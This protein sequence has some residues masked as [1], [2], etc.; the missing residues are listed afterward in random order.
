L[1][2]DDMLGTVLARPRHT[3]AARITTWRQLVDI[4]A[5]DR[6]ET[7]SAA[8]DAGYALLHELRTEISREVRREA[9]GTLAG[10]RIPRRMIAYFA[11]EPAALAAPMLSAANMDPEDLIAL[12]P[13]MPSASRS[14]LRQRRDLDD[15]VLQALASFGS[16][17]FVIPAE[18]AVKVNDTEVLADPVEVQVGP[19][20]T[21]ESPAE[22]EAAPAETPAEAEAAPAEA[23]AEPDA[24]PAEAPTV[25]EAIPAEAPIEPEASPAEAPAVPVEAVTSPAELPTIGAEEVVRRDPALQRGEAQIR[26]LVA[27]IEAFR[28]RAIPL[29]MPA[30]PMPTE[31]VASDSFQWPRLEDFRWETGADGV[32]LWVEGV[33]REALIGQSIAL[34]SSGG[35][36]GVDAQAS[37]AYARRAPFRDARLWI[38]GAGP[39]SGDWRISAVP[40][41]DAGDGRFLGYRGTARRPRIDET[42]VAAPAIPASQGLYG[43]GLSPDSLR[44]LVHELRTPLNAILGFAEMIDRELLGPAGQAY[45]ERAAEIT[46]Q[47]ARLIAA[48]DD[49]DTAARIETSRL[50]LDNQP[51]EPGTLLERLKA[52]YAALAASRGA[53]LTMVIASPLPAVEGDIGAIERMFTRLLASTIGLAEPGETIVARL[54]LE[55]SDPT[56]LRFILGQPLA[57][58]GRDE[59]ALLDPAFAME[60]HWPDAPALG[61]GFSLRLVRHLARASG[62]TLELGGGAFILSLPLSRAG[63]AA[64]DRA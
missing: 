36:A 52:D 31:S 58:A 3:A 25:S 4:L 42:A 30:Q 1:Y 59:M 20:E 8:V 51:L 39:A 18:I 43:T 22:V 46:G 12:L 61:L 49:L 53:T 21:P 32:I 27:R 41:F 55:P 34:A 45:R 10:R 5:R 47:A 19:V 26:E 23:A 15:S 14:V 37:G 7:E 56:K 29:A 50:S 33:P 16:T 38:A 60:G 24:A 44:Q 17:D 13:A 57:L 54:D 63:S 40:F 62:G 6:G 48:V 11:E 9:V 2:F 64:S 28:K 35:D